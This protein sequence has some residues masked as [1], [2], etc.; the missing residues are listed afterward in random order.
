M[1][2][3]KQAQ[4]TIFEMPETTKKER[5]NIAK[6]LKKVA[7]DIEGCDEPDKYTKNPR[8]NLFK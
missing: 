8:W 3:K 7:S 1:S 4:L 5:N 2:D 6:W